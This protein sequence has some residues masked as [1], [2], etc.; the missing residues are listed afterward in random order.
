MTTGQP[1]VVVGI[2]ADGWSGL[3]ESA[4]SA[5]HSAEV[6]VGSPRQLDLMS[7][8]AQK[9]PWPS[10]ML[11]ALPALFAELADRRVCVL[12][13]GDPMFHGIGV[14]L[15]RLLGVDNVRVISHPSSVSLAAARMGWALA[16]VDVVS[17]VN[18]DPATVLPAVTDG[19][20]LLVLGNGRSTPGAVAALLTRAGYGGTVMT[21]LGSLGSETE[22]RIDGSAQSWHV[23]DV[24]PLHVV[25]LECLAT[26]P[27]VRLTRV[28]GLPDAAFAGDGQMTKQE[29]R[30]L[31]LCALAPA[32]GEHL[33]D[34]GGGSG[35]IAIEWM[36]TDRRCT[37]TSFEVLDGRIAQI[38]DNARTLGVPALVV[39]GKAPESFADVTTMPDAIFVGGGVTQPGMIDACWERLGEGGRIVVNAVTAESEALL[40]QCRS[41]FGGTL[42]RLQI[43]RAEPLGS[44][45]VWRSQLPVV[46]WSA[47]KITAPAQS[48]TEPSEEDP[49]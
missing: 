9:V 1:V 16:E 31:T 12:A 3:S 15:I 13:S 47:V 32:P 30:A 23:G 41:R 27:P 18:R 37:A 36:R 42:R 38:V 4:R 5:V 26:D 40:V 29:I 48:G 43:Q 14:T 35:T 8:A 45:H 34:V 39:S 2:G 25:A 19:A 49:Q 24:D 11:P 10:P 21:V 44:F 33:W 28:P 7:V 22:S 6:L 20:R 17:V 46:Q